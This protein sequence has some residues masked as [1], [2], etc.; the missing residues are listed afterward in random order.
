[1][2]AQLKK[3]RGRIA[4]TETNL[5]AA[6]EDGDQRVEE[7]EDKSG[8]AGTAGDCENSTRCSILK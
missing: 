7:L 3:Q 2:L 6:K 4:E 8:D 1:M 5:Q